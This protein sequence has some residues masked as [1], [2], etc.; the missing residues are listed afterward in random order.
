MPTDPTS[1][2]DTPGR[3]SRRVRAKSARAPS[4]KPTSAR[5]PR[6][7]RILA[8]IAVLALVGGAAAV[9]RTRRAESTRRG[10][11]A[12]EALA[13][14]NLNGANGSAT[15]SPSAS[16]SAKAKAKPKASAGFTTTSGYIPGSGRLYLGAVGGT[17]A[18]ARSTGLTLA[19]HSY[20]FF[21][22]N[23]PAGRMITVKAPGTSWRAVAAAGP[24]SATYTDII[25]WARTIKARSGPIMFAYH[26]EPE[27]SLSRS[28]GTAADF[29][30]AW[31]HVVTIFR[32]EGVRNVIYTLQ[33][34]GW[35]FM[36]SPSDS[37]Y[38]AK[39]YPGDSYVDSIGSDA[40]NWGVCGEGRGRWVHFKTMADPVLAFA[41][42]HGKEA[43][44]PEFASH[45]DDRRAQWTNDALAYL[46]AHRGSIT[47]AFYFHRPPT[48]SAN[49]DCKWP[50]ATREEY[51]AYA[52]LGRNSA[53]FRA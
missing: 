4:A 18:L 50:L 46:A 43:S 47:G 9:D 41:R 6:I 1:A 24:G 31:R 20:G 30:Q 23:V 12:T 38:A 19:D 27:G 10:V 7:L 48:V 51:F 45:A 29:I 40:Y 49:S 28:Y 52:A 13:N 39:W 33:L 32:A 2:G 22:R 35:A 34:T 37:R 3:T 15:S 25:R 53:Y 17:P 36:T 26:H 5:R 14:D 21:N 16:R 44:F 42:A 11:G 8:S